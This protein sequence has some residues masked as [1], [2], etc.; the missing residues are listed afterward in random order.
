LLV[1][2]AQ[3]FPKELRPFEYRV[4]SR[5]TATRHFGG[6]VVTVAAGSEL[7]RHYLDFFQTTRDG[8]PVGMVELNQ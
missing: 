8:I 4:L 1:V 3:N 2:D 7:H 5:R 6:D